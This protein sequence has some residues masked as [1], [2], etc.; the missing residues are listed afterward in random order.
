[1]VLGFSGLIPLTFIGLASMMMLVYGAEV[2]VSKMEGLAKHYGISE[3]V[4]AVTIVS[5]GTSL[6]EI[7]LQV[8]GSAEILLSS[9]SLAKVILI[10]PAASI[11]G[12]HAE[13][14]A[15][16]VEK[17]VVTS[18]TASASAEVFRSTSGTVMGA[19]IGSDVVQE[20]LVIGLVIISS[21]LLAKKKGFK[22]SRKFLIR[23]YAPMIGTTIITLVLALNWEGIFNFLS[24]GALK[25]NGTLTRFDGLILVS[26]FLAYVYYL[27]TTREE[28]L[29]EKGNFKP[30]QSPARDLSIGIVSML[31]VVASAEVFLRVVEVAV[32]QT[33]LSGSM[34]GVAT[35]GIV[36]ALPEMTT[37]ISGLR[38][39][40]EGVS[41][42]TLVGS[43]V[44]NPLLAI[45][46]GALISSYAVP[47]PLVLWDL[48]MEAVL[49]GLPVVY[50]FT[51]RQIGAFIAEP[52][53]LAGI[54]SVAESLEEIENQVLS[55]AGAL[56]LILLYF[57]YLYIRFRYF[58]HDFTG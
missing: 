24:G 1:M 46:G 38:H 32:R 36:S 31:A 15:T 25:L 21:A 10:D 45:G 52:F 44:T 27:Y 51:R 58:P 55:I 9:G 14:L 2:V 28:E 13:V 23:D 48:P 49:A 8:V 4:I 30:S 41:L 19:S 7:A 35:V 29:A 34:I 17:G 26:S 3:V 22:F 20:T 57:V 42:G 53:R 40:S 43:N 50:L 33:E 12:S 56:V 54:D 39:G 16:M 47:R 6:P 5:V 11:F 37:A 18:E